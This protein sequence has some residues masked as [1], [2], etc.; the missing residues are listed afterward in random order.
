VFENRVP[1]RIFGP[2][3]EG[4]AGGWRRLQNEELHNMYTSQI[5]LGDEIKEDEVGGA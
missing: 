3:R 5:L 4:A 2:K 1:R